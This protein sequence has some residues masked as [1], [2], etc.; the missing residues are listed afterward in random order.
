MYKINV[1]N[2]ERT[3]RIKKS[4]KNIEMTLSKMGL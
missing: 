2:T 3:Q 1:L 4:N